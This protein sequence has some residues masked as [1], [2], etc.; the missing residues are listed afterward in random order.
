M[1]YVVL[2]NRIVRMRV[3][4]NMTLKLWA[5]NFKHLLWWSLPSGHAS[6]GSWLEVNCVYM[7]C[8]CD[9]LCAWWSIN[10]AKQT[11]KNSLIIVYASHR[12]SCAWCGS[13]CAPDGLMGVLMRLYI[14]W[15]FLSEWGVVCSGGRGVE[16]CIA[17]SH[18]LLLVSP[19]E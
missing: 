6:L 5:V 19:L 1:T 17:I 18:V 14:V 3:F 4:W 13:V 2:R 12:L 16:E 8:V 11:V 15:Q 9:T 10:S 7:P